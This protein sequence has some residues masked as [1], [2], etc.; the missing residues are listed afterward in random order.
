MIL[1]YGGT[2][3]YYQECKIK[4][5]FLFIIIYKQKDQYSRVP[6]ESSNIY[7]IKS[8]YIDTGYNMENIKIKGPI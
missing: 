2:V 4:N 3:K 6:N 8:F 1:E 5:L 7:Y